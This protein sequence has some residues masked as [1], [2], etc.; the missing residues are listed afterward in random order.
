VAAVAVRNAGDPSKT[1]CLMI[2]SA[3]EEETLRAA[4]RLRYFSK[5][6]FIVFPGGDKVEE[7]RFEGTNLLNHDMGR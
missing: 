3:G 2:S 5:S 7:G 1:I 4:R 6:G